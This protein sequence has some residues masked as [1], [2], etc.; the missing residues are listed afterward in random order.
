[1]QPEEMAHVVDELAGTPVQALH[2]CLGDGRTVL[3]DST[4]TELWGDNVDAWPHAIFH[5]A[6]RNARQLI[7]RG[8]D[9]LRI[10]CER[11]Q[12]LGVQI[13]PAVLMNQGRGAR[14]G[15]QLDV[16]CSTWRFQ[17]PELEINADGDLPEHFPGRTCLDFKHE[18]VRHERRKPSP[19]SVVVCSCSQQLQ[20]ASFASAS[21]VARWRCM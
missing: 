10:V 15:A 21:P 11:G 8:K 18:A 6:Y 7:E 17:H 13:V 9:P 14:D 12:E 19:L 5:R 4:T 20:I 1:M 3:H 16:R 2:F